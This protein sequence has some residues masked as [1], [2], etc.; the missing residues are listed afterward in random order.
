MRFVQG[1]FRLPK[2]RGF[3]FTP[4]YYDEAKED[5][6]YRIARAKQEAEG[7]DGTE[8]DYVPLRSG[9]LRKSSRVLN[10]DRRSSTMRLVIFGVLLVMAYLFF[11]S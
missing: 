9:E 7:K 2:S 11:Y 4:R 6:D 5:L 10:K 1:M 8:E 3:G